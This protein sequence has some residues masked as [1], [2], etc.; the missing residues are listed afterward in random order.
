MRLPKIVRDGATLLG[1]NVWAQGIAL[2]AYLVLGR[3]YTPEDFAAYNIF[4][5]YIEVLL[6]LSTCKYELSI[7]VASSDREAAAATRLSLRLNTLVSLLLLLLIS[8][9]CLLLPSALPVAAGVALMVPPMVFFCG[10]A[11]VYSFLFNRYKDF[12]PIALSEVVTSTAGVLGKILLALPRTLHAVGLPLGTV[13][14]KAAGNINYLFRLRQLPSVPRPTRQERRAAARK[15]RNFPLYNMPKELLSSLSYNLPFLWLALYFP[16]AA[17][18]GLFG[19]A[20]TMT[21]RP[22]NILNAAF[23]KLLY[24]RVAER[25]RQGLPVRRDLWRFL[26]MLNAVALPLFLLLFFTAEPLFVWLFGA[27]WVGTG[28]YVR[29]L[30]PWVYLSLSSTSLSFLANIYGRQRA[31]FLWYLLLLLLRVAAILYGI[32]FH[33]FPGAILLFSL[34]SALHSALLLAWYLRLCRR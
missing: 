1:G 19:M 27:R 7:V 22:V 3:L 13:L 25:V 28:Y 23:E 30:L 12:A 18:V 20:L 10:T 24:P 31:E 14:G 34:L 8:L 4:Y 16:K 21:F 15:F 5:S 2:L 6:I 33:D 9:L 29:C 26:L 11:R 17:C 32:H